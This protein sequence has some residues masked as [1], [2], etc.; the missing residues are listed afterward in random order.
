LKKAGRANSNQFADFPLTTGQGMIIYYIDAEGD[1]DDKRSYVSA[2][3]GLQIQPGEKPGVIREG[4]VF[5]R[6]TIFPVKGSF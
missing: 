4:G 1:G 5:T 3:S 2:C 6:T